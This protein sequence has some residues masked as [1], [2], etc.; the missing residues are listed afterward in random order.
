MPFDIPAFQSVFARCQRW[1]SAKSYIA[2]F[3]I[4]AIYL[5]KYSLPKSAKRDIDNSVHALPPA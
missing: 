5:L 3:F 4:L 2:A 1:K